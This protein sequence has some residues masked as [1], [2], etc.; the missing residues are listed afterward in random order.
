MVGRREHAVGR[1]LLD[2]PPGIEHDDVVGEGGD[3]GQVVADEHEGHAALPPEPL[4]QLDDIGADDGVERGNHLV[5]EQHLR[6]RR[7]RAGEVD[8]LLLAAGKLLGIA[9]GKLRRQLHHLQQFADALPLF[10]PLQS[11]IEL[12][13]A[14]QNA[15]DP[16]ARIERDI[17]HLEHELDFLELAAGPLL[18]TGLERLPV[19]Q[20]LSLG[21][22]Q[23]AGH[24]PREGRL[25]AARLADDPDRVPPLHSK[26][27][28]AQHLDGHGAV[29]APAVACIDALH[30]YGGAV[31]QMLC[32]RLV[33]L[34]CGRRRAHGRHQ[35]ARIVVRRPVDDLVGV[36]VLQNVSRI[37]HDDA[38]GDLCDDGE[39]VRDIERRRPFP[40]DDGLEGLEHLDLGGDVEGGGRLVQNQQ[41]RPAAERHGRHQPLQLTARHLVGVAFA[42]TVRVRQFKRPVEFLRPLPGL[43]AA[44]L[45]VEDG[46]LGHLLADGQ[47]GIEGGRRALGQIGDALAAHVALLVRRHGDHVAPVQTDFAAGELQA[48]L[49]V[50][51]RRKGDGGL[52]RTRLAD[53]RD[54]LAAL[55]AEAHAL[56]DRRQAAV[57]LARVDRQA[58]DFEKRRHQIIL[59]ASRP[60]AWAE[61]S[62]TMR[63]MAMVSVAMA[64]AGTS[65]AMEP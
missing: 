63:F 30:L 44:H 50:S 34:A 64:S 61:T 20:Y 46:R 43:F 10:L 59:F 49:R 11:E 39:V 9:P 6:R 54:H 15:A 40:L 28:V 56:D 51:E 13:R 17:R 37:E 33:A 19:Q 57:V 29:H 21:R 24:D 55:D 48:G 22:G 41:V 38:V 8:A 23:Q 5:A 58:V 2:H 1:T 25:A 45:A 18:E 26:V 53:E 7:Q 36:A 60:P 4:E 32:Q 35:P 62:S 52:S 14:A 27:N 12:Q 42:E 3:G 47:R 16:L 65:G 31:A